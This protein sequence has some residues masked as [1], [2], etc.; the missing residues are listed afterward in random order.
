MTKHGDTIP[1]NEALT[2]SINVAS[3]EFKEMQVFLKQKANSLSEKEKKQIE[4]FALQIK[5]EDLIM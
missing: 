5:L 2:I 1:E 4:L 3:K